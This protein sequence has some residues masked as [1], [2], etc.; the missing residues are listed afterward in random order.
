[1]IGRQRGWFLSVEKQDAYV[2]EGDGK[3]LLDRS[4]RTKGREN[5]VVMV[6]SRG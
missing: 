3:R 2:E 1:M 5:A 6:R 4:D